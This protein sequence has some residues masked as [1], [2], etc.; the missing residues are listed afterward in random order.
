FD[1]AVSRFTHAGELATGRTHHC[2]VLLEDGRILVAGGTRTTSGAPSAEVFD[3]RSGQSRAT[4]HQPLQNRSMY[5]ATRLPDGRVLLAGGRS[6]GPNYASDTMDI[7]NPRTEQFSRVPARLD[8]ARYGHAS[9]LVTPRLLV[10]YGG[11]A[12]SGAGAAPEVIDLETLTSTVLSMPPYEA[13]PRIAPAVVTIYGGDTYV[14]GGEDYNG[15]V[16]SSLITG[17]AVGGVAFRP[18]TRLQEART[19]HAAAGL[20]DGRILIAGGSAMPGTA[21]LSG[22]EIFSPESGTVVRGP[23]MTTARAGHSATALPNGRVLMAGGVDRF[24]NAMDSAELF[25]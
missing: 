7:F 5:T 23:D 14:I 24:G 6:A 22:T 2:G 1:A 3:P 11:V 16:P 13:V 15:A 4:L 25:G 17:L 18:A 8:V 10:L 19:M 9:A 21:V 20:T 12:L